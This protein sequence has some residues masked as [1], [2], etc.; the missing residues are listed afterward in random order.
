MGHY[1]N[2]GHVCHAIGQVLSAT[3]RMCMASSVTMYW[4]ISYQKCL[5]KDVL[6]L[7]AACGL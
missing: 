7:C 5:W 2:N 1:P 4:N 6:C 3:T